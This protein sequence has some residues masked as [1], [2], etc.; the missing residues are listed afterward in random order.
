MPSCPSPLPPQHQTVPSL[1]SAQITLEPET[2]FFTPVSPAMGAG[3][4][5][6]KAG[7]AVERLELFWNAFSVPQHDTVLSFFTAQPWNEPAARLV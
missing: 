4:V 6:P 5:D 7:E 2:T 3:R 1:L